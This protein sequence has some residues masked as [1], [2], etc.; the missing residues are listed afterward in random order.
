MTS[1]YLLTQQDRCEID[2]DRIYVVV[3]RRADDGKLS[4]FGTSKRAESE[5]EKIYMPPSSR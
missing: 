4:L 1:K 2:Q 3:H 5:I